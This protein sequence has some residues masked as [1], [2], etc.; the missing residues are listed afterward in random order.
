MDS[1]SID[2]CPD[3]ALRRALVQSWDVAIPSADQSRQG[4]LDA[5]A[6]R[7][8]HLMRHDFARLTSA[9]YLLDV[10]EEWYLAALRAPSEQ[11]SARRLAELILDREEEKALSRAKYPRRP[12]HP[13]AV[14]TRIERSPLAKQDPRE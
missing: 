9:L 3:D 14:A 6:A 8:L 2:T 5:L 12:D 7:V 10:R 4:L 11:N 1:T 13:L